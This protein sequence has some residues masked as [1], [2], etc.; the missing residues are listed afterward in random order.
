MSTRPATPYPPSDNSWGTYLL[1]D[2]VTTGPIEDEQIHELIRSGELIPTTL[3]WRPGMANWS[4]A[5]DVPGLF[6]PPPNPSSQPTTRTGV[7]IAGVTQADGESK[8]EQ[9]SG[10]DLDAR[11]Y[12]GK[13][14]RGELTLEQ[15]FLL[16]TIGLNLLAAI[17]VGGSF[18]ALSESGWGMEHPRSLA[19]AGVCGSCALAAIAVWQV[20]GTWRCADRYGRNHERALFRFL[21]CAFLV[22]G[23]PLTMG[24]YYIQG[25]P[26]LKEQLRI[27]AGDP[28]WPDHAVSLLADGTTLKIDGPL[29]T[30]ITDEVAEILRSHP[31]VE[32]VSIESPGGRSI[33]AY[34]LFDLF[35]QRRLHLH[36][37]GTCDSACAIA[38][39]GGTVRTAAPSSR[40]G[41]H[42][43]GYPVGGGAELHRAKAEDLRDTRD[44]LSRAGVAH[45]LIER[46]IATP[47]EQLFRP[48]LSELVS[49]GYLHRIG[50][51]RGDQRD[52]ESHDERAAI[53]ERA[54]ASGRAQPPL[55]AKNLAESDFFASWG[56]KVL[57][58]GRFAKNFGKIPDDEMI[59]FMRALLRVRRELR[60][61]SVEACAS[62]YVKSPAK[63][64]DSLVTKEAQQALIRAVIGAYLASTRV[65]KPF[66][67]HPDVD[68]AIEAM[69]G[70]VER[71]VPATSRFMENPEAPNA[72]PGELCDMEVAILEETLA[73]PKTKA[74]SVWRV[75]QAS[76]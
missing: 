3:V 75:M 74:A 49:A 48:S 52:G 37:S 28:H 36:A 21:V 10:S 8:R 20:V 41:F 1:R 46:V 42:A 54:T 61:A 5:S 12:V 6:A 16:N 27:A 2:G 19:V 9:P 33:E 24:R 29:R 67:P 43:S 65:S 44:R 35:S 34:R 56:T 57:N 73:L 69:M 30:G 71:R 22:V 68:A 50:N 14:W 31:A 32:S 53:T 62:P 66:A 59:E 51:E 26:A 55:P 72:S 15:S 76:E 25:G 47:D 40:F 63:S 7:S 17:A 64:I 39:A 18:A 11:S 58:D 13:H 70:R 4:R 45:A 60:I 38:F 23:V